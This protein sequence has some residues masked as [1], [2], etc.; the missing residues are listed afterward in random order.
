MS[1]GMWF[2]WCAGS[3]GR[4]PTFVHNSVESAKI[5]AERLAKMHPDTEFH[6]LQSIAFCIKN[7]VKWNVMPEINECDLPF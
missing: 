5:E 4:I 7:E 1:L 3:N 2:V 6:V